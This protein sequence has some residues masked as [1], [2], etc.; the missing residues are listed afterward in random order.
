MKDTTI[1]GVNLG[2]RTLRSGRVR[3]MNIE[4]SISKRINNHASEE[5]IIEEVIEIIESVYDKNVEGIGIGVPSL[6]NLEKGIVYKAQKIPSWREVHIKEILESHF[7]VKVY[8]NN[9]ANCFAVGEKYFGIAKDYENIV[10]LILSAGVGA[11]V[12]FKGHLYSGT[13]C[14]VGEFGSLPYKENDFEYY[15]SEGYFEEKYGLNANLVF[16]RA[17]QDDKIALSIYEQYGKDVG[18]LIKAIMFTVDPEIIVIG[19]TMSKAFKYFQKQMWRKIKTFPYKHSLE[20]IKV[21]PSE[22]EDIGVLGAVALFYDAQNL[23]LVKF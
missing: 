4:K 17:Q 3:D 8:V 6:V 5:E 16:K 23:T 22:K 1:I 9:D 21:L 18:N 13:N 15:C 19:G 14:G 10:G 20:K 7:G 11:G 2:V 12:V